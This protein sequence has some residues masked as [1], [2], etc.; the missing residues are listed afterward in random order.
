MPHHLPAAHFLFAGLWLGCILTEALFERVLGSAGRPAQRLLAEL[1][2]KVDVFVEVP[3]FVGVLVTG[4]LMLP[5]PHAVGTPF[6]VMLAVGMMAIFLNVFCV[7]LVHKR[8]N[9]ARR[10]HWQ[11]FDKLDFFQH[12][13][14]ALV[15]LG[16]LVAVLAGAAG[17]GG[18]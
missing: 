6:V 10:E 8:R 11:A 15:L 12:K 16:V 14:G 3:A 2:W 13:L 4:A 5:A 9:A 18:A 7:W 17:R 1:H